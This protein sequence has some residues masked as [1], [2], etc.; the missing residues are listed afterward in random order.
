MAKSSPSIWHLLNNVKSTVKISSNFVAFLENISFNFFTYLVILSA[1]KCTTD[2]PY[3]VFLSET[4][5]DILH[6]WLCFYW[7]FPICYNSLTDVYWIKLL[8]N[9]FCPWV[10]FSQ[11]Q[12]FS[13]QSTPFFYKT[14]RKLFSNCSCMF[15]NPNNFFQFEF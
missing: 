8:Q 6:P 11:E 1:V 3:G 15:L 14:K 5:T 7:S 13:K 2:V 4:P 9:L 12:L 10:Y